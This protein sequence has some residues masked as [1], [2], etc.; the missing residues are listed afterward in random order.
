MFIHN[1]E[2]LRSV[3]VDLR[4]SRTDS[5][6]EYGTMLVRLEQSFPIAQTYNGAYS[7]VKGPVLPRPS[8][9]GGRNAVARYSPNAALTPAFRGFSRMLRTQALSS[10]L[11]VPALIHMEET[12][13][14][15][16]FKAWLISSE[17]ILTATFKLN[18]LSSTCHS[19]L[20]VNQQR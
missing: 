3:L 9:C 13:N 18:Q 8:R 16:K 10:R 20:K 4:L 17:K 1:E 14:Y 12:A 5:D 11:L 2:Q 19:P 7:S 6:D 15:G